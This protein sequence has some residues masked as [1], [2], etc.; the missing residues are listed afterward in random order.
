M[1]GYS[2]SANGRLAA[3]RRAFDGAFAAPARLHEADLEP[4]LL[5]RAGGEALALRSLHIARLARTGRILPVPSRIPELL[6]ITGIRGTL[7]AVFDLAALLGFSSGG[8]QPLWLA[9]TRDETP[10]ALAFDQV[11]GQIAAPRTSLYEQPSA[12]CEHIRQ[13]AHIEPTARAVADIPA[14]VE[15]L[16]RRAGLINPDKE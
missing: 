15:T 4:L 6:G 11:E 12:A 5:I 16:R 2:A 10:V 3:M 1:N 7:T 8:A 14:I 9:L 13:V